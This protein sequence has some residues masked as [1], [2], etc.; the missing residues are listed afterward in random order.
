MMDINHGAAL[1]LSIVLLAACDGSDR[2]RDVVEGVPGS[3]AAT[4]PSPA[5]PPWMQQCERSPPAFESPGAWG[6]CPTGPPLS[7]PCRRRSY[8]RQRTD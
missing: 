4:P 3:S 5:R 6:S 8:Y 1:A 2:G 7:P